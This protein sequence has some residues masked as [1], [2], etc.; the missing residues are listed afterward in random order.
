MPRNLGKQRIG[1]RQQVNLLP[2]PIE[3]LAQDELGTCI[4]VD[5]LL[6]DLQRPREKTP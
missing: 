3:D 4:D 6:W 1:R 5:Q 2:E